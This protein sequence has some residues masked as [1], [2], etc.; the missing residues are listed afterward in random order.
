MCVRSSP[1]TAQSSPSLKKRSNLRV[2]CPQPTF[3]LS[4]D[5]TPSPSLHSTHMAA[6]LFKATRL[7]QVSGP[8]HLFFLSQVSCSLVLSLPPFGLS[9]QRSLPLRP[10]G[11]SYLKVNPSL[12]PQGIAPFLAYFSFLLNIYHYLIYVLLILFIT[13]FLPTRI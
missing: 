4:S 9:T 7:M 6:L 1:S 3:L 2:T 13:G 12:C 11:P 5:C 8:L 10:S